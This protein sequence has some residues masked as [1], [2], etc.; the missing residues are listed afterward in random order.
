MN[1]FIR[2]LIEYKI[3]NKSYLN[4]STISYTLDAGIKIYI[5]NIDNIFYNT[6]AMANEMNKLFL[7]SV[8]G[9]IL[10]FDYNNSP[11]TI[12]LFLNYG[13]KTDLFLSYSTIFIKY[14]NEENYGTKILK[15]SICLNFIKINYIFINFFELS[16]VKLFLKIP[17]HDIYMFPLPRDFKIRYYKTYVK[18]CLAIKKILSNFSTVKKLRLLNYC[19]KNS[20]I[21]IFLNISIGEMLYNIKKISNKKKKKVSLESTHIEKFN[22]CLNN[23]IRYFVINCTEIEYFVFLDLDK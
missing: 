16:F 23:I 13:T 22:K 2:V 20:F 1:D 21:L 3:G 8:F 11:K 6:I 14:L 5:Y 7:F 4:F 18:T 15:D 10:I 12:F 19:F 9:E 17:V